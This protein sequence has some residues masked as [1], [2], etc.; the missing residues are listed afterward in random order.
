MPLHKELADHIQLNGPKVGAEVPRGHYKT[1]IC[2]EG[3]PIWRLINNPNDRILIGNAVIGNSIKYLGIIAR[4]FETNQ[5][6]RW[7][8]PEVIPDFG[9]TKWTQTEIVINR[10]EEW[11][12]PSI[13]AIGVGGTAVGLHF[14][15]I[16]KDDL[17][18]EDHLI[19][20]EQMQKPIDWHKYSVSLLVNPDIDTEVLVGTRWA[21]ADVISYVQENEPV[22]KWYSRACTLNGL[23]IEHPDAQPIFP[24]QF[25]I[26][27]LKA[28]RD[29]QGPYI[30]SCQYMNAPVDPARQIFR[31]E[32]IQYIEDLE[33]NPQFSLKDLY[34]RSVC[35]VIL[36][37]A[38]S[39]D[40]HGDFTGAV[41]VFVDHNYD[42][43]IEEAHQLRIGVPELIDWT[44]TAV[45]RYNPTAV[46]VEMASL[47][48][49]LKFPFENEMTRK[50]KFFYIQELQ[51]NTKIS[52][53]MRIRASLQPLFAQRKVYMRRSQVALFDQLLKFPF[54]QHDDIVDALAYLPHMWVAGDT[55]TV[56]EDDPSL[57]PFNMTHILGK[58]ERGR[59]TYLYPLVQTNHH[60]LVS[61]GVY[62]RRGQ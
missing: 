46:G 50:G 34:E 32:W 21:F 31:K 5:I 1:T 6:F 7:L 54:G 19:S 30:F 47:L 25:P 28:I 27:A 15:C 43:Y 60:N 38:L 42:V 8:F 55:P 10:K 26:R 53:E 62:G 24:E 29:R 18:N 35:Y 45:E 59:D 9:K 4:H 61:G 36:D 56:R 52:K 58:L 40:R 48:R 41:V 17:V 49:A 20:M 12:E 44:F 14:P 22:F 3:Y 51:P 23:D 11:R 39:Q 2:T 13:Q 57:D 37:P 33:K 16:I